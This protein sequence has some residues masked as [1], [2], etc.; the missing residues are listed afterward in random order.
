MMKVKFNN[1]MMRPGYWLSL[2]F[3]MVSLHS[4]SQQNIHQQST[5]YEWPTDPL[6]KEKLEQWRDQK[7]GMIIHWGLYAVPGIIESWALVF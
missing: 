6:V 1:G 4:F 7:F 3:L 2:C 5:N